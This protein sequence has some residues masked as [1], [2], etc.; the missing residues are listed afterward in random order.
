M[1][2][3]DTHAHYYFP[4]FSEDQA[5]AIERARQSGIE[6]MI[7]VG[8]GPETSRLSLGL[9]MKYDF[10]WASAGIHPNDALEGTPENMRIIEDLLKEPRV[11]AI[12][13]IGL[14]FYRESAPHD[15]QKKLLREFLALYKKIQK[16]LILHCREAYEAL[17]E[18]LIEEGQA[19]Y[20]GI[21]H[22]FSSDKENMK[23]F[24]DLGFYISFAGPLTYKKNDVLREACRACPLDRLLLETDAPF[25]PPQTKRGKRNESSYL[26]E[27]AQTA[28]DIH[29]LSLSKLA[30]MTTANARKVF[31][32]PA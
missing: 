10:I 3:T 1:G 24:L 29:H 14:D 11:V 26:L 30:E 18:I 23:K 32:L 4:D 9:A 19:P 13:E 5:D 7:N 28:A 27:T 22:C 31:G 8:T 20:R 25:L 17:H 21:M 12:G 6:L 16:P 2:F 15:A